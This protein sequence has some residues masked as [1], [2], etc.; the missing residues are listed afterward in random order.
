MKR[1]PIFG[2]NAWPVL[3]HF[4]LG[5]LFVWFLSWLLYQPLYDFTGQVLAW[6]RQ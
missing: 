5:A 6:L 1:E 2:S 3:K 4:V